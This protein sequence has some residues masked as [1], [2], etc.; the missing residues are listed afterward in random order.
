M[1][2]I[3]EELRKLLC[4][5]LHIRVCN[6]GGCVTEIGAKHKRASGVGIY[7]MRSPRAADCCVAKSIVRGVVRYSDDELPFLLRKLIEEFF[8]QELNIGYGEGPAGLL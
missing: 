7:A 3:I 8:L 4:K 5:W 6:D 2:G 1:Q